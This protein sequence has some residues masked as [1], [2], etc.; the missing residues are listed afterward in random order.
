V[1]LCAVMWPLT[2][3]TPQETI[4]EVEGSAHPRKH[5]HNRTRN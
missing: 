2:L 1:L 4:K 5:T 3:S